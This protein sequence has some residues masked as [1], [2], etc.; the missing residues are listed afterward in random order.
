MTICFTL[1]YSS[2]GCEKR[3]IKF[4]LLTAII[5]GSLLASIKARRL[6]LTWLTLVQ[7]RHALPFSSP[8]HFFSP[9]NIDMF[10]CV[11]VLA[12]GSLSVLHSCWWEKGQ[13]KSF[14][15]FW[16]SVVTKSACGDRQI[17]QEIVEF[18]ISPWLILSAN[19]HFDTTTLRDYFWSWNHK[20]QMLNLL[21]V[22]Y[23]GDPLSHPDIKICVKH[24]KRLSF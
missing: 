17:Y 3:R 14:P 23:T 16:L 8:A 22:I 6:M 10:E 9:V 7:P 20:K 12:Y 1:P 2:G 5:K 15:F 24:T 11:H 21:V 13:R 18:T 19:F 4:D